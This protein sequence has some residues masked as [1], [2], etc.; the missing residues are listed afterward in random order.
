M[1]V[2][3]LRKRVYYLR[4]RNLNPNLMMIKSSKLN[5]NTGGLSATKKDLLNL[6]KMTI[7]GEV[8]LITQIG[9]SGE[10]G[11]WNT[12]KIK[13]KHLRLLLEAHKLPLNM[14]RSISPKTIQ[15]L[16]P[17]KMS[18]IN[19]KKLDLRCKIGESMK[20]CTTENKNS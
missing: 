19:L 1:R 13:R 7:P 14:P 5:L 8:P 3:V 12:L 20:R 16:I 11:T 4:L 2:S 17:K 10:R 15:L 18:T 6:T 9:M